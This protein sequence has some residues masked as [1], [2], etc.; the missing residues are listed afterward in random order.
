ML[1]YSHGK[2]TF[3]I[4][5]TVDIRFW[6]RWW[7]HMLTSFKSKGGVLCG[8][9]YTSPVLVLFGSIFDK[10]FDFIF[11]AFEPY[12]MVVPSTVQ[13]PLPVFGTS[14]P[15]KG[16]FKVNSSSF[17]TESRFVWWNTLQS[18]LILKSTIICSKFVLV[19]IFIVVLDNTNINICIW[20]NTS[21]Y[22]PPFSLLCT[23]PHE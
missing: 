10:I 7:E 16:M 14:F 15:M 5:A 1:L 3:V 19:E 8:G 2:G 9:S 18:Q 21:S 22:H 23:F 13:C 20:L 17:K 6:F 12:H 4:S 11:S